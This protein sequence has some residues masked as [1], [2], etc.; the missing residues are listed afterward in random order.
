MQELKDELKWLTSHIRTE[1]IE[2]EADID[3]MEY[4]LEEIYNER[5]TEECDYYKGRPTLLKWMKWESIHELNEMEKEYI[6]TQEYEKC[7]AIVNV[8][9]SLIKKYNIVKPKDIKPV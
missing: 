9:A 5:L 3:I 2:A 6:A 7:Q 4:T 8:K 1:I